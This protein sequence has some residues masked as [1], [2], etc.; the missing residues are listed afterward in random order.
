MAIREKISSLFKGRKPLPETDEVATI[1]RDQTLF[2]GFLE[3]LENP[4]EVL[5]LECGGDIR[6]Y[7]NIGRDARVASNLRTRAQAVIGKEWELIPASDDARDIKVADYIKQVLLAFPFDT[8][9]RSI[10]RGGVLKGFSLS[11]IMWDISEG[12]ISIKE[13]KHRAQRRFRFGTDESLRLITADS[14]IDGINLTLQHPNKFQRF[15]F[16]DEPET[17]YGVGLGRELYWPWWFK[18]NGI[19]FWLQFCERFGAPTALGRYPNGATP[20]QKATLM[21]A[22]ETLRSNSSITIPDGMN[23]DLLQQAA[24]GSLTTQEALA[25]FMGDE[26]SICILGQTASTQGTSGKLGNEESQ[27]NVRSDLVKSDADIS[28][29]WLSQQTV[30]WIVDYQFPGLGRYPLFWIRAGDAADLGKLATRDKTLSE[31]GV[32]FNKKYFIG[33]Y[34]LE[35]DDFDIAV[36]KPSPPAPEFAEPAG[37]I[38]V[39]GQLTERLAQEA[40]AAEDRWIN[41]I[42]DLLEQ[43]ESLEAFRDRLI[44]LYAD[45]DPAELGERLAQAMTLAELAGRS[46]VADGH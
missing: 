26:I 21:N 6:V 4:D 46:E 34:G 19:K 7:D 15:T 37:G 5:R 12:D 40:A 42:K 11:E 28:S 23:I 39:P 1:E 30:R 44:D 16:G 32:K 10:L 20:D 8:S 43:S 18:K 41:K 3:T 27:E 31:T 35:D 45:L 29:E 33:T 2:Q 14:P 17:P 24:S 22:L 38:D 9:R 13:M 36:S 25:R